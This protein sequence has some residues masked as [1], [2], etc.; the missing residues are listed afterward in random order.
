MKK[1]EARAGTGFRP[2]PGRTTGGAL[3]SPR[4][5]LARSPGVGAEPSRCRAAIR[6]V[7]GPTTASSFVALPRLAYFVGGVGRSTMRW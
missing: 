1:K 7:S 5:P 2:L 3:E 4:E 6:I